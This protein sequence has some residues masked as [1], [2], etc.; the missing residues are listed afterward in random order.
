MRK[1]KKLVF[2]ALLCGLLTTSTIPVLA[3]GKGGEVM[4]PNVVISV[5]ENINIPSNVSLTRSSITYDHK[6]S[7]KWNKG[8][9]WITANTQAKQG[10]VKLNSYTR[11]RFETLIL[12]SPYCDSG[13]CWS[14][15]QGRSY[16]T[17]GKELYQMLNSG[18]AKTYYGI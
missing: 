3:S 7:I 10:A 13:R 17:S 12:G 6:S 1:I 2:K 14:N 4:D 5:R 8:Y 9:R 16:A 11:A 15:K 18:V